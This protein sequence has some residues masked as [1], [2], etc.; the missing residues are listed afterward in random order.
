M[1]FGIEDEISNESADRHKTGQHCE[2]IAGDGDQAQ[3]E[4]IS[5]DLARQNC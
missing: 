2:G 1:F 5:C 4:C 3:E